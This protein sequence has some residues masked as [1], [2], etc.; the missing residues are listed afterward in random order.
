MSK[1]LNYKLGHI[2]LIFKIFL[3]IVPLRLYKKLAIN[4][5][6]NTFHKYNPSSAILGITYRCQCNCIHCSAGLYKKDIKSELS[7]KEW[8]SL[9]DDIDR[10]GVPRINL[11]GGEALLREDLFEIIEYA[12]RKFI[13]ILESNGQLLT[14]S[15]IKRLKKAGLSC[16]AV[17]IDSH[18]PAVHDNL[19]GLEGC[20]RKAI[21]GIINCKK[22]RLPCF[23]STYIPSERAKYDEIHNL[24]KLAKNL[25]I[26]AI[27]VLPPRP[28]GSFSCHLDAI[29]SKEEEKLILSSINPYLAYFKGMPAP[30]MCGIFTKTTFYIS[31]YGE[32]QPC[33]FM[34][35]S[36]GDIK[37]ESLPLALDRMWN[38]K[39]FNVGYRDC[40]IL[41]K[42]FYNKNIAPFLKDIQERIIFPIEV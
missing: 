6:K 16:V 33:P 28:V 22:N 14:E 20:F 17:S 35:L 24:M 38:H 34:P 23:L 39:I 31:P 41:N 1:K 29:L 9:L 12:S 27:R 10:L 11:S 32:I 15:N 37:K 42:E 36:F 26:L 4:F 40:L 18:I 25:G 13:L 8:F 5:I 3:Y 19:R 2:F 7:T 30:K 21:E